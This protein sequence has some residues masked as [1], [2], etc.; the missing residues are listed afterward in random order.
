MQ[1]PVSWLIAMTTYAPNVMET[2]GGPFETGGV[3]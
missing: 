3:Y 2:I 1:T